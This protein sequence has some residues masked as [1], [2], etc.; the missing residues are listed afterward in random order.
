VEIPE[1][2][3]AI[4]P[5]GAYIA[6]QTI[7]QGPIDIAWQTGYLSLNEPVDLI[8]QVRASAE[9]FRGLASFSRLILHDRRSTGASSRN[10]AAPNLE[11][12]VGDLLAVLDAAGAQRPVAPFA[13]G[14][15]DGDVV[16]SVDVRVT[17]VAVAPRRSDHRR[18][19]GEREPVRQSH[20]FAV[21]LEEDGPEIGLRTTPAVTFVVAVDP[22]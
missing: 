16:T 12:R 20:G 14:A 2:R 1:T 11:T 3:Y 10:V 22:L 5:D 17:Q 7:G 19:A 15:G 4:T 6:Y 9:W 21:D 18:G 8:W 13:E